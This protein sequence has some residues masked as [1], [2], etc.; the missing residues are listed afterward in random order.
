[1]SF[2][3]R[4]STCRFVLA[5]FNI[6]PFLIDVEQLSGQEPVKPSAIQPVI[7]FHKRINFIDPKVKKPSSN[8]AG[9]EAYDGSIYTQERGYGWIPQLTAFHE[10]G[11]GLDGVIRQGSYQENQPLVFRIDLSNGWYRVRCA[12]ITG[13][14][15]PVI[16]QRNFNCRAQDSVFAGSQFGPPL[17]IRGPGLVEGANIVE[18]TNK[19]LRI[20]VGDPAYG[21]WTWSYEGPWH[22]GWSTWWGKWGDHRY[23][24]TWYQKLTRV[25][26]PGFHHLRLKWLEIER[27]V[28]PAKRPALVFRDFFNRDDNP[29]INSGVAE[30][31]QWT[32]LKIHPAIPNPI[33]TE[34]Y[35][36][37]LKLTGPKKGKG[38]VGLVQKTMIPE[39]G[40]IRYSTRVSLFTGEGSKIHSGSQEAGLLILGGPDGAAEFNSTFIGV[41]FDRSRAETPGWVRYRVGDGKNG[42]RTNS[43]MPD[44]S[45]PFRVTEGEYEIIVDHDVGNNVLRRIQINGKDITQLL[46]PGERKQR[47][48]R[49]LFGIRASMDS[50]GSDVTLKQFY[51]HYRVEDIS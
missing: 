7:P 8:A 1:M 34:L 31:R 46:T 11:G 48:A 17:K 27:V 36:T 29:D 51:W 3:F 35:R 10:G 23:A 4:Q 28:P 6:L 15:L 42:Y 25:I 39:K 20:V 47:L 2:N 32:N 40:T 19:H 49:G 38:I 44:S 50:L 12:S 30:I 14:E 41:A 26:D 33:A 5:I 37:S 43:E 22:R 13:R 45:L 18:V 16:D 9:W 24:E 21:G